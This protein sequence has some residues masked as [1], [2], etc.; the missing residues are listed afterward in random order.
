M[1]A[2][3]VDQRSA[4]F[5]KALE[6]GEAYQLR[7]KVHVQIHTH[8]LSL[9]CMYGIVGGTY[10]LLC[11]IMPLI[12]LCTFPYPVCTY[13]LFSLKALLIR[14]LL[15]KYDIKVKVRLRMQSY[16]RLFKLSLHCCVFYRIQRVT[17]MA[18]QHRQRLQSSDQDRDSD[19]H[20]MSTCNFNLYEFAVWYL[21][22]MPTSTCSL[23]CGMRKWREDNA[24]VC[25][26]AGPTA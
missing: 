7:T 4:I 24:H 1:Y 2:R 3:Q 22:N 5:Q 21:H 6:V 16:V 20:I 13:C 23:P 15:Q 10:L 17:K 18:T 9:L 12:A 25:R 11:I 19:F 8:N 14:S 26:H